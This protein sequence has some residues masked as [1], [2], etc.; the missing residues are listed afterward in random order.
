MLHIINKSP[1]SHSTLRD[2]LRICDRGAAIILIE[3]GV[4]AAAA[5]TEWAK[6]LVARCEKIYALAPDIAAR[7]LR[8]NI[9]DE[10][11]SIDYADFVQ[12][13]C[14]HATIQSWY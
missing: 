8:G 3:D 7:G 6:I 12:L 10:I 13:C 5:G 11:K 9:A 1:F 2:C 4:Y 14:E